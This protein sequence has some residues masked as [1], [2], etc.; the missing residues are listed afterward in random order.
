MLI[1]V[2]LRTI[3]S[4]HTNISNEELTNTQQ[5]VGKINKLASD[6]SDEM[7]RIG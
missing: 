1:R 4:G 7:I 2:C 5:A 3:N 6:V